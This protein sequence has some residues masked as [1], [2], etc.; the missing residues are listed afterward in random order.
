M[1]QSLPSGSRQFVSNHL[2]TDTRRYVD[3]VHQQFDP[4]TAESI[5]AFEAS[6]IEG[7]KAQ[8]AKRHP[9]TEPGRGRGRPRLSPEEAAESKLKRKAYEAWSS[10]RRKGQ[11]QRYEE[12]LLCLR[13]I[14]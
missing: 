14:R 5:L 3:R 11:R 13:H 10:R 4:A 7:L 6:K 2:T 9:D 1:I 8:D 12:R